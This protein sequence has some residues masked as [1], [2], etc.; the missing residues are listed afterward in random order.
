M[1]APEW[2]VATLAKQLEMNAQTW[3]AL[4]ARGVTEQ[5]TLTLDFSYF[6]PDGAAAERLRTFL[7]DE[8]DY[9]VQVHQQKKGLLRKAW[10]VEGRTQPT[11][12]SLGL[13]NDWVRWMAAA[14]A[15]KGQCIFDGWGTSVS[16]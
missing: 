16:S 10:I 13:L 8:T 11:P 4:R 12:V 3:R 6:A 15:E 9:T 7:V 5:S 14:G 2:F 1:S